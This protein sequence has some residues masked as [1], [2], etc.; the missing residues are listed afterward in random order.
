[1]IYLPQD[2]RELIDYR[3]TDGAHW[4]RRI[5]FFEPTDESELEYI[6]S[7]IVFGCYLDPT[8]MVGTLENL[9]QEF[10]RRKLVPQ[11]EQDRFDHGDIGC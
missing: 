7:Q 3:I 11:H 6:L 10:S 1:M 9:K 8:Q 2:K 5:S 4:R